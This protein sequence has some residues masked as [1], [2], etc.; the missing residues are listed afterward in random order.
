[1]E[2]Y[3]RVPIFV[4][5]GFLNMMGIS[6]SMIVTASPGIHSCHH[7]LAILLWP[8]EQSTEIDP[9]DWFLFQS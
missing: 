2:S 1:M 4:M 6:S 3:K 7:P 9:T 8:S 5:G